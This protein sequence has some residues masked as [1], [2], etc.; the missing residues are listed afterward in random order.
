MAY[1]NPKIQNQFD[2]L[3]PDLKNAIMARDATVNTLSDLIRVLE[4]IVAEEK[5]R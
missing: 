3:S 2:T 4:D 1:I 5:P